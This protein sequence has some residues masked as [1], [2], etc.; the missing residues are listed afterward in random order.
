MGAQYREMGVAYYTDFAHKG[1]I[2]WA[3]EFGTRKGK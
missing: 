3:Q 1:E 2:Y